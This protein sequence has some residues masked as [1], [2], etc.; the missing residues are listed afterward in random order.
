MF[1]TIRYNISIFVGSYK[2]LYYYLNSLLYRTKSF[3]YIFILGPNKNIFDKEN[4]FT[5]TFI[6]HNIINTQ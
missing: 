6:R 4:Q 5:T 2:R 3:Q 1:T